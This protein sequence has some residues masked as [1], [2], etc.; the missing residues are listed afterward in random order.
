MTRAA[1]E[2]AGGPRGWLGD[3][4][5]ARA[6]LFGLLLLAFAL[7]VVY[8]LQIRASP[9]FDRPEMDPGYHV[10]WARAFARGEP[11]QP[12]QPFFRAPLYPW[13][14]GALLALFGDGLLVPRLV[15]AA[16]GTAT[17]GLAYLIG[18]RAFD[19]ATGLVAALL[20]ATYWVLVYFDGELLLEVLATPLDLL[21]LWLTLR[22]R[23]PTAPAVGRR[24]TVLAGLAWGLA[25]ITRPNVLLFAPLAALW[26][27]WPARRTSARAALATGALFAAGLAAPILPITAIN[28]VAGDDWVLVS[29]QGGVN[30]WIGN[31]P[32]SDGATAIVPGTRPDWWGGYHDAIAL[33]ERAEGR[34]LAASEVSRH[35]ARRAWAFL[36]EDPARGLRHLLWKARLFWTDHELGNNQEVRFFAE[37]FGPVVRF[38]PLGFWFVAPL[39]LL[40]IALALRRAAWPLFPLWGFVAVYSV[41]V[42]LFFVNA[43]F[44]LPVLPV[45]MVFAAHAL[46][47][48]LDALRARRFGAAAAGL[49]VAVALAVACRAGVPRQVVGG[50]AAGHYLL[51]IAAARDGEHERALEELE[52][53]L[54]L[55][56][57]RAQAALA[58]WQR[59]RS[60]AALGRDEEALRDLRAALELNPDDPRPLATLVDTHLARGAGDAA[61][62]AAVERRERTPHDPAA[63]QDV[64]R[65]LSALGRLDEAREA[66]HGALRVDPEYFNAVYSLGVLAREQGRTQEARRELR[67]AV[68]LSGSVE[69]ERG[70]LAHH[71]LI[72]LLVAE[73]RTDEARDVAR[74]ALA[75]WPQHA[76]A[77]S[78]GAQLGLE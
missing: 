21:A 62:A 13:F 37:R 49:G 22:A 73:G 60:L 55:H 77:R 5:R 66:L 18:A 26:L 44:R 68:E 33:A 51:G 27:A 61:L 32:E 57:P 9:Y 63:H 29:S 52:R 46:L 4:R 15:Q 14:L 48:W 36:L 1:Q 35:Y 41:S 78:L 16:L 69:P 74:D 34:P 45:L 24:R 3:P 11:F 43:R 2:A 67:R 12:G 59:G 10:E 7:R 31:N 6:L 38:L 20:A 8:V 23:D 56:P 39:G 70:L 17:T 54:E 53:S 47:G 71:D 58:R 72:A 28:R 19:R 30:L 40:G 65:S 75:R 50:E 64:A 25:T 42:V 76:G